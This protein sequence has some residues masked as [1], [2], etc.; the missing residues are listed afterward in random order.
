MEM[1]SVVVNEVHLEANKVVEKNDTKAETDENECLETKNDDE[2]QV[3]IKL[4]ELET[5]EDLSECENKENE[6]PIVEGPLE[7]LKKHAD[8]LLFEGKRLL[9]FK[10]FQAAVDVL[11]DACSLHISIYGEMA[12][13]CAE[14]YMKFGCAL[15]ELSKKEMNLIRTKQI[16]NDKDEKVSV[17]ENNIAKTDKNNVTNVENKAVSILDKNNEV[18]EKTT[19]TG[20]YL[21]KEKNSVVGEKK[22]VEVEDKSI[23]E[24]KIATNE[25]RIAEELDEVKRS[26]LKLAWEIF[27]WVKEIY[28]N[29][30]TEESN[31]KLA[32]VLMKCGEVNIV[33]EQYEM[34]VQEITESLEIRR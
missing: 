33:G 26:D 6:E 2:V 17:Q 19:E 24:K 7:I 10:D 30:D 16:Y 22:P 25:K 3:N 1:P 14:V 20:E 27:D 21:A 31:L 8:N 15:L 32:E 11:S 4:E 34:A 9:I 18:D 5:C 28:K 29:K 12:E 13:A 23:E